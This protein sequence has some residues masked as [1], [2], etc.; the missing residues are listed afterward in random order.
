MVNFVRCAI[1]VVV[2]YAGG[3]ASFLEMHAVRIQG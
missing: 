1:D 3:I 2:S